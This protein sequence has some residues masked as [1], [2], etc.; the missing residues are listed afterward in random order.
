M[1]KTNSDSVKLDKFDFPLFGLGTWLGNGDDLVTAVN[2][3]LDLGIR[4]I[5]TAA[6]YQNEIDVGRALKPWLD[7]GKIM[8]SDLT[9]V[10]KLP[11]H[12]MTPEGVVECLEKSLNNLQLDYVDLYLIH[13][14]MM[15]VNPQEGRMPGPDDIA[16][17][18]TVDILAIWKAMEKMV[19]AGKAK[20]IG[21]S[22]FSS[23]QCKRI[24]AACKVPISVNQVELNVHFQQKKLLPAMRQLNI[25]VMAHSPL[26]SGGR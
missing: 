11:P 22:N 25:H 2:T 7:S 9:V 26:G 12:G 1:D 19:H 13:S 10:T 16:R 21:V 23:E 5:D 8:R 15:G 4:L 6:A 14:P 3:A 17:F 24:Q 20:M 18:A